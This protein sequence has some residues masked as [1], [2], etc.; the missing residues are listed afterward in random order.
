MLR[1]SESTSLSLTINPQ[2]LLFRYHNTS[3]DF[4]D[5]GDLSLTTSCQ[6]LYHYYAL[7]FIKVSADVATSCCYSH[8]WGQCWLCCIHNVCPLWEF[9]P[10]FRL[11]TQF[12]PAGRKYTP[13]SHLSESRKVMAL[14][15]NWCPFKSKQGENWRWRTQSLAL[16][17]KFLN[18]KCSNLPGWGHDVCCCIRPCPPFWPFILA[19]PVW[20]EGSFALSV[21]QLEEE[22]GRRDAF[23]IMLASRFHNLVCFVYKLKNFHSFSKFELQGKSNWL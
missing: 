3:P 22:H 19:A 10:A 7:C 18:P 21:Q 23:Q 8:V 13:R 1:Q 15:R 9:S 6:L 4:P 17:W 11:S 5:F 14:A 20:H 2:S 12:I 16:M